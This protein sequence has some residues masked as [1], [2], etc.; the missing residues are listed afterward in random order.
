MLAKAD[1]LHRLHMRNTV[2]DT[3]HRFFM[4]RGFLYVDTPILLRSPGMEPNLSPFETELRTVSPHRIE[5]LGLR[6]SP[7]YAMK[8][9]VAAGLEKIYTV[10]PVFRNDEHAKGL[11]LPEFTMLEWYAPGDYRDCMQ[12]TAEL[13]DTVLDRNLDWQHI[14][15]I[16]AKVD[17]AG[18]LTIVHDHEA[19]FIYDYPIEEASLAKAS[20]DGRTG[21][22]FE[23]FVNGIELCNGF[24]E[25]LD[26][27]EQRARFQSEAEERR[28]RGK[29]VYPIDEAYLEAIDAIEKPIYGNA[30]GVDRLIMQRYGIGD[31][32]NILLFPNLFEN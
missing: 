31:I 18:D 5:K 26:S 23:A 19:C 6:T 15:H 14:E 22:R 29:P 3:I 20:A 9:L 27:K 30:L 1:I 28:Q 7:E 32:R 11:H 13:I 4:D 25:L 10:G 21:E 8:K 17:A 24:S 2:T 16:N 12:E